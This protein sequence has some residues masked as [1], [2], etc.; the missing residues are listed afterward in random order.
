[1]LLDYYCI[2]TEKD[3]VSIIGDSFGGMI[4]GYYVSNGDYDIDKL[5]MLMSTLDFQSL[6]NEMYLYSYHN[7]EQEE[8][9]D[10][11]EIQA[12]LSAMSPMNDLSAFADTK[13][14]MIND[15]K[16]QY[17]PYKSVKESTEKIKKNAALKTK[18]TNYKKH[19]VTEKEIMECI[20]F[21][22]K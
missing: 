13:I 12:K 19:M 6:E 15:G 10:R 7:G 14:L 22:D 8:L 21:V 2:D 11:E 1:M 20:N 17:I 18:T 5:A 3:S 4:G 16:D 9:Q